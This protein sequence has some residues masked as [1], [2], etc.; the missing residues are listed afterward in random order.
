MVFIDPKGTE[1]T[2]YKALYRHYLA[3]APTASGEEEEIE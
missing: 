2:P 1:F 3:V